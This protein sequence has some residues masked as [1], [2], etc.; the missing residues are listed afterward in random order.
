VPRDTIAACGT[1]GLP[2]G[3]GGQVP[4]I[5]KEKAGPSN[6]ELPQELAAE[7]AADAAN[8]AN[9]GG[10]FARWGEPATVNLGPDA[11]EQLGTRRA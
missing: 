2:S 9:A 3:G 4:V 5:E 10:H 8:A 1:G 11:G 7:V 6:A